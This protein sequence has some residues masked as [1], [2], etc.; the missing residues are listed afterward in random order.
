MTAERAAEARQ[1]RRRNYDADRASAA[2]ATR[3][4]SAEGRCIGTIPAPVDLRRKESCYCDLERYMRTYRAGT[5]TRPFCADHRRVIAK[6]EA[7]VLEGRLLAVGMPRGA[8]KTRICE[9]TCEWAILY[10]HRAFAVILGSD[11]GLAIDIKESIAVQL[12]T[13]PLL[14]ADFPEVC[15]PIVCLERISGRARGQT[16]RPTPESDPVPTYLI[17]SS[18]KLV[19]PSIRGSQAAGSV[20]RAAGLTASIR[21]MSH[22]RPDGS[23]IR[24]D[25]LLA[26]DPQTDQ[27][28]LSRT[29]TAQRERILAA[30][31]YGMAGPGKKVAG[32]MACTVIAPDDLAERYLD[33]ERHPEWYGERTRA[34]YSLPANL[35][36]WDRYAEA[37]RA[38]LLAEDGGRAA[39]DH[40]R[41]HRAE[42][43]AGAQVAW[44]ENIREGDVSAL[45]GLMN[46]RIDDPH[47]FA[48]EFQ[49][50]PLAE[51][52]AIPDLVADLVAARVTGLPRGTVP[53]GCQR[54]TAFVDVQQTVL[55]WA[56]CAW[57]EHFGG[58]VIDYGAWPRQTR[59]CWR[60]ADAS[61][62]LQ[63]L[64]PGADL[65]AQ[66]WAGL[67]SLTAELLTREW[68]IEGGGALAIERLLIDRNWHQSTEVVDGLCRQSPHRAL[69]LPSRGHGTSASGTPVAEWARRPGERRGLHWV[70]PPP[71]PGKPTRVCT[72]DANWWK[73]FVCGRLLVPAG[74]QGGLW[75]WGDSPVAHRLF[76]DHVCSEYK[77]RVK[78]ETTGRVW[79]KWEQRPNTDNHWWDCVVGCAVAA[80]VQGLTPGGLASQPTAE[81]R[82]VSF[83]ERVARQRR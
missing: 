4:D 73:S 35:D 61:P 29:Q 3:H 11:S 40:Y 30:A 22:A 28:A 59:A 20:I 46:V 75:L 39:N 14:A 26:D 64:A 43:E 57:D 48:A 41:A 33:R 10:G 12:E 24:P 23:V 66:L 81:R 78:N 17:W 9:A 83:A 51:A 45:Q 6:A 63:Q 53:H 79:D 77:T 19:L 67:D 13:N 72:F 5:F 47:V 37:R 21:G 74:G 62:T 44:P 69:L 70:I 1:R 54:V 82:P 8:G 80:S 76:V 15:W 49:N 71:A 34:L 68:S 31:V 16:Y 50:E 55:F 38:G 52:Q 27:S 25:L 60:L 65:Q 36:A 56:A 18:D 7:V 2:A 42:L 58:A 32:L